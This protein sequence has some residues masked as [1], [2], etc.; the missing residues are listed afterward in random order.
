MDFAAFHSSVLSKQI[1]I[2]TFPKSFW[3]YEGNVFPDFKFSFSTIYFFY[4][5]PILKVE[6]KSSIAVDGMKH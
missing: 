2:F 3:N 1:N 6:C 5:F 4:S